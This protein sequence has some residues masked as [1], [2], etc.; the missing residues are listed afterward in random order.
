M[1]KTLKQIASFVKGELVGDEGIKI[2]GLAGIEEAGHGDLTFLANPKYRKFLHKTKAS[3]VIVGEDIKESDVPIIRCKNPRFALFRIMELFY[4][5]QKT[6]PEIIDKT[7][8][9]GKDM[10]IGKGVYIGPFTVI[11]DRVEI[12]DD[13]IIMAGT[14][15]GK[16]SV[17]KEN[18]II[19]PNVTIREDVTIGKKVI[20]HS[21]T[22]IGADGFGYAFESGAYHKIPQVGKVQIGD[23]VEIGANVCIDRATLG[24][25]KIG[26]GTKIDNLVQ[27]GHNVRI[28][29]NTII[30]AQ[31]GI[32]GST[33]IGDNVIIAGQAGLVGHIK[34]GDRVVVGAQSGISKD[35]PP[36]TVVFG[37][38]AREVRKAKKIEAC[39]SNFP[40]WVK[41][42]TELEK[43]IKEIENKD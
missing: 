15:I 24:T 29:E 8:V 2:K 41:R 23:C 28:G 33:Q 40:Q 7:A 12:G 27:I 42:I 20:V 18:T 4:L 1:E 32:S 21:G 25:T 14:F 6:F 34:I 38:P 37:C 10:K 3:A 39:I 26:R 11:E 16:N 13:V 5:P 35:I 19:Y 36:D 31:V 22:V 9:M 43:K 17:I 30:V